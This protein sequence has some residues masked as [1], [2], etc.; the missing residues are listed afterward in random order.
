MEHF[1]RLGVAERLRD[2]GLPE[3]YPPD[4]V[5]R[6]RFCGPELAR[7]R[8]PSRATLRAEGHDEEAWPTPELPNRVNQQF[9]QPVL[10]E[11]ARSLAGVTVE[12]SSEAVGVEA[13]S[14]AVRVEIAGADGRR[15][16]VECSYLVGCDGAHSI[17]RKTLGI[18]M[19][20]VPELSNR[21][22][23]HFNSAQLAALNTEPAWAYSFHN[24]DSEFAALFSID[25]SEEWLCHT[26]FPPGVDTSGLDPHALIFSLVGREVDIE[27]R[28]VVH[29]TA[30]ALV[31]DRFREGRILLAG[32]AAHIWVPNAGFGMNAGIQEA[33]ELGWMLAATHHGWAGESLLD[34]YESERRPIGQEVADMVARLARHVTGSREREAIGPAITEVE[35]PGPSGD[36]ARRIVADFARTY[37]MPQHRPIGLNFGYH[38]EGSPLIVSDGTPA[39]PFEFDTFLP[40]ARPG[41]RLPHFR[42]ADGTPVFDVLGPDFTLLRLGARAPD[43]SPLLAA[44]RRRHVP[45]EIIDLDEPRARELY[46]ARLV[47]VR[48]DQHVAWRADE[49]PTDA[50]ALMDRVR[51]A[52]PGTAGY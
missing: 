38:Y 26:I 39:P 8:W 27:L 43:P 42:R 23:I 4:V 13:T 15:R 18:Q 29:W 32:D 40:D 19:H 7:D 36:H 5:V 33:M 51:G 2:V 48:P 47:L 50:L 16:H 17:V 9:V 46:R 30:R 3:H 52:A 31:A 45:L 11:H 24:P 20:G 49:L 6:T 10:L 35:Q 44:A 14:D 34:G 1:R 37:S 12:L 21:V 41:H 28:D 22:S 25:G